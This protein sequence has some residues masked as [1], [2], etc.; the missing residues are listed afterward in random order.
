M[1]AIGNAAAAP[2]I[3]SLSRTADGAG[4][5]TSRLGKAAQFAKDYQ[6]PIEMAAKGVMSQLPNP[7]AQRQLDIEQGQLDVQ[8]G[9]LDLQRSRQGLE[10]EEFR[11]RQRAGQATR[12]M[13][14]PLLQ[15]L[16][17]GRQMPSGGMTR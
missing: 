7:Q 14:M 5:A 2:D 15:Q 6:K 3:A 13:L 16:M 10:E 11:G 1:G 8:R 12:E 17:A 4:R 9:N